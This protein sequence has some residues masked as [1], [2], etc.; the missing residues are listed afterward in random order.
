MIDFTALAKQSHAISTA[1]GWWKE[2]RSPDYMANDIH[3][4]VAGAWR[5]WK[6]RGLREDRMIYALKIGDCTLGNR[7]KPYEGYEECGGEWCYLY[8]GVDASTAPCKPRGLAIELADV[9]IRLADWAEAMGTTSGILVGGLHDNMTPEL[10]LAGLHSYVS[11]M[12]GHD[13]YDA[14]FCT[15]V[16]LSLALGFAESHSI[17]LEEAIRVKMAWL[18]T[19]EEWYGG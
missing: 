18:E 16:V 6:K 4:H 17:P 14:E 11:M 5:Q 10:Y 13:E 15:R 2:D 19:Q 1:K 9:V 7:P 8:R 12:S 3:E